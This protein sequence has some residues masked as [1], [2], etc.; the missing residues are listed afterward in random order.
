MPPSDQAD[1]VVCSI[2]PRSCRL[3]EGDRGF[4]YVR[5]NQ[6]GK[7]VSTAYGRGVGFCVDPV[8]KKPLFQFYPGTSA[9]S[10]G[11]PGCNLSCVFC[12]NWSM[13][14]AK[15][16]ETACEDAS[17]EMIVKAASANG[18]R[19][20]AFTYNDPIVW[21][22]YAADVARACRAAGIK[23]IAVTSGY[24]TPSARAV[25]F[26]NMDAANVDL[27]GFSETFY[28]R[29]C[30]GS[31]HPVLDT[32]RWLAKETN[33]WLEITNLIVPEA[34]D[35]PDEIRKMCDWLVKELG[36]DSPLHFSA[37]HPDYKLTDRGPTPVSTLLKATALA[38]QAGLRYVYT[39]NVVDPQNQNTCCPNCQKTIIR[40]EGYA[41]SEYA[42]RGDQ[43]GFCGEKIAGRFDDAPGDWGSRRLPIRIADYG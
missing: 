22:E 7:I 14:R 18:C 9:L 21:T 11:T 29:Y 8:E 4:C 12:Q 16:A 15:E 40:R 38:R 13:S 19:S 1:Y 17:P 26:E 10:F 20:V 36:V 39:G 32:L 24:I 30:K 41:L 6:N 34:N 42:L 23:T 31:L 5:Q 33:V 2:C 3:R 27:K 28:M 37:F 43:C 35:A 25:L